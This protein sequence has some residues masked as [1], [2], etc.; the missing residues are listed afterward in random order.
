MNEYGNKCHSYRNNLK[1]AEKVIFEDKIKPISTAHW[2]FG[3]TSLKEVVRLENLDTSN[4]TNMEGMFDGCG[5]ISSLNVLNFDTSK[6]ENMNN[7]FA[8]CFSLTSLDVSNWNVSNVSNMSSMFFRCVNLTSLEVHN[9]NIPNLNNTWRM[10]YECDNLT[11]PKELLEYKMLST[12]TNI[13]LDEA[14]RL[15]ELK[16]KF[17][18]T[19]NTDSN[20]DKSN[21]K[22]DDNDDHD[23]I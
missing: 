6:V 19:I 3:M 14:F 1:D 9:W 21:N 23:S 8:D 18:T 10:F 11:V 22:Y 17:E 20:K 2:F 4:T 5:L 12:K 13:G 16:W 7:M 15:Q